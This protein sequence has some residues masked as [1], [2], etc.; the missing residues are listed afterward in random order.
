[1]LDLISFV[2]EQNLLNKDKEI[3]SL[4][5]QDK[6]YWVKKA[7]PTMSSLSH[8][9]YYKIFKL[10]IITP[11]EYKSAK[12]ALEFETSKLK[13]FET[14]GI[15]VP[16]VVYKEDEFFVL[17]DTGRTIHSHIRKKD[18]KKEDIFFFIPKAI[19]AIAQIHNCDEYHGG[20]QSRNLTYKNNKVYVIDLED[21]FNK[22]VDLKTLQYRD[23]L[24]FLLSL[25][26]IKANVEID[27]E[28][29]I[30]NYINL[31]KN[32]EFKSKLN[33][34]AKKISILIKLSKINFIN[35]FL[36]SDVKSFFKLFDSLY[37]LK[38]DRK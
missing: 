14:L 11:V 5:F 18:T 21:S 29:I 34:L 26:K 23:F 13:R 25:T 33:K 1:M 32:Y 12:K 16:K 4:V 37:N 24:L 27:Y 36:G 28:D 35:K 6:K 31:T 7:R 15:N 38:M 19:E 30:D 17:E 9:I 10:E 3:Y 8:K 22:N 20:T 2:K